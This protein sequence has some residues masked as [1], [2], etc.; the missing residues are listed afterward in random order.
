V[1]HQ[2]LSEQIRRGMEALI[3]DTL[4]VGEMSDQPA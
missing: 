2:A 4:F 1:S 3:Q